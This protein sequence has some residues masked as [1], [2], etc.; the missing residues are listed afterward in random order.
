MDLGLKGMKAVVTGGTRG[1]GRAIADTLADEGC[2][3]ALCARNTGQVDEAVAALGK[4]GVTAWGAAV[5]IADGEALKRFIDDAAAKLGGLDI[6]VVNASALAIGADE[7][8][9]RNNFEVDVMGLARAADAAIPYLKKSGKGSITVIS[10]VSAVEAQNPSAY[11]AMKAAQIPY[12]KGLSVALA[13]DNIRANAV[14][15]GTIFFEGGVWDMAKQHA[16]DMYKGA[17]ERNPM[18]RMGTPQEVAN[19]TVFLASPAA[20]FVTG[21][22]LIVDGA[23]TRR[24]QL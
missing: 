12:I 22:N 1:I 7:K 11:A 3:V 15:P 14:S 16:P 20:S 21:A 17:L 9:F 5:D 24:V 19:A 2:D 13:R 23:I 8:A 18:G 10:S 6:L 4:R